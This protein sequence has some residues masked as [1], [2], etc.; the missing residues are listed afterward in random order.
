MNYAIYQFGLVLFECF[1]ELSVNIIKIAHVL[2][3][4]WFF[5]ETMI[6]HIRNITF[7]LFVTIV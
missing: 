1:T 7:S 4:F 6:N 2:F 5:L 3:L